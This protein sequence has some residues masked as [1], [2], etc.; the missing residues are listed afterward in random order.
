[1]DGREGWGTLR[2][3]LTFLNN[4]QEEAAAG[5]GTGLFSTNSETGDC[6][7]TTLRH[8]IP[9]IG[10]PEERDHS[11]QSCSTIGYIKGLPFVYPIFLSYC[12]GEREQLCASSSLFHHTLGRREGYMRLRTLTICRL[13]PR[14]S[15]LGARHTSM[16]TVV[17]VC[18][19]VGRMVYPGIQGGT[20]P[21]SRYPTMVPREAYR[22]VYHPVYTP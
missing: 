11:T 8:I 3:I 20:Y 16:L 12:P 1:M 9:T 17:P 18:S 19:M 15:S 2:N 6:R 5:P 22:Q 13:E 7:H 4:V 14:A 10:W 21:G